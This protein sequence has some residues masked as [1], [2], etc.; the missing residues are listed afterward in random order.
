MNDPYKDILEWMIENDH[1]FTSSREWRKSFLKKLKEVLEAKS[2]PPV[3][4][5]L[6]YPPQPPF[7]YP[8]PPFT[9]WI[10]NNSNTPTPCG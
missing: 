4:Y 2:C 5:P 3:T 8:V 6:T 1:G 10:E 7:Y 9:P